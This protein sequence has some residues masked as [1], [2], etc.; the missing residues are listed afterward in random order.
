M[1]VPAC[2]VQLEGG[3]DAGLGRHVVWR[4]YTFHVSGC[5]AAAGAEL[6][7]LEGGLSVRLE[8][9]TMAKRVWTRRPP[10]PRRSDQQRPRIAGDLLTY[11]E[12]RPHHPASCIA[13]SVGYGLSL[14]MGL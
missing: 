4:T 13:L 6:A 9:G 11:R 5:A 7:A 2:E 8:L 14:R 3:H 1:Q 12:V 10:Q